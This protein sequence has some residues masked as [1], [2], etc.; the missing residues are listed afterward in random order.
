MHS[1]DFQTPKTEKGTLKKSEM[2]HGKS[3]LAPYIVFMAHVPVVKLH[4]HFMTPSGE[5]IDH[6]S[7]FLYAIEE[8]FFHLL[9]PLAGIL[10]QLIVFGIL[11]KVSFCVIQSLMRK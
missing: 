11:Y 1:D 10:I 8:H 2:Q 9:H 3:K 4:K 6:W 5:D 7:S